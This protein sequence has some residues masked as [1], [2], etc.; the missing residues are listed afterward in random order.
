MSSI[1]RQCSNPGKVVP[2]TDICDHFFTRGSRGEG[3]DLFCLV[4]SDR[5]AGMVSS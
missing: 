4:T 5:T 2:E 3:A 1:K